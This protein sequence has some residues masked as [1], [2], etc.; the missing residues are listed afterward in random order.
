MAVS[1]AVEDDLS[2]VC[3]SYVESRWNALA[4]LKFL[5][6]Q[7]KKDS[8]LWR[9]ICLD[10]QLTLGLP[11]K[12]LLISEAG[13][14]KDLCNAASM[15]V[16]AASVSSLECFMKAYNAHP[17]VDVLRTPCVVD[18][19]FSLASLLSVLEKIY[20]HSPI[21][22]FDPRRASEGGVI[23]AATMISIAATTTQKAWNDLDP[24]TIAAETACTA[25]AVF[26]CGKRCLDSRLVSH[27]N[28]LELDWNTPRKNVLLY[29][30]LR[31][32]A[33]RHGVFFWLRR[34]LNDLEWA[35]GELPGFFPTLVEILQAYATYPRSQREVFEILKLLLQ[36]PFRVSAIEISTDIERRHIHTSSQK[37]CGIGGMRGAALVLLVNLT[38]TWHGA[39]EVL[40]Y[41]EHAGCID[42]LQTRHFI[43]CL[44]RKLLPP[45]SLPFARAAESLLSCCKAQQ[46]LYNLK[47]SPPEE[48]FAV[49]LFAQG[50]VGALEN[51][52]M[53]GGQNL[54]PKTDSNI[55]S[56]VSAHIYSPAQV[57]IVAALPSRST[58]LKQRATLHHSN[59]KIPK[60]RLTSCALSFNHCNRD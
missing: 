27:P 36:G 48:K 52:S 3:G 22:R 13:L 60:P 18:R 46:A 57:R 6:S 55:P 4:V 54:R 35:L 20:A 12:D 53:S 31:F 17:C 25:A 14:S 58:W 28:E 21:T 45:F 40:K 24:L 30:S 51:H 56:H 49:E 26:A 8:S 19:L 7:D 42:I 23:S 16:D 34:S 59:S 1:A 37:S 39:P 10:P 9:Y 32:P 5:K 43:M 15:L 29:F 41:V 33:A 11:K 38:T 50:I 44:V 47:S 2:R